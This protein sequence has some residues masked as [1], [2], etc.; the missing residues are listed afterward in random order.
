MAEAQ[1]QRQQLITQGQRQTYLERL[2]GY[3]HSGEAIL[4]MEALDV[5]SVQ[6]D[7]I[8]TEGMSEALEAALEGAEMPERPAFLVKLLKR[9][10]ELG[11]EGR[12]IQQELQRCWGCSSLPALG[13]S[14]LKRWQASLSDPRTC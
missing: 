5:L 4:V 9:L 13:L 8:A 10:A 7:Y 6:P 3:L 1:R 11:W 12:W 2:Q 14:E